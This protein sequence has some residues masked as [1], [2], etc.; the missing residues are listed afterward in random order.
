MMPR[1]HWFGLVIGMALTLAAAPSGAQAPTPA[2]PPPA[3]AIEGPV[4]IITFFEVDGAGSGKAARL[5]RPFAAATRQENGNAGFLALHESGRPGRFALVETW[6]DKAA[7]DAHSGAAA[8]LAEKL[9]PLLVAPFDTRLNG[10]LSVA[11]PAIGG[12][13]DAGGVAAYVLTHVDVFPAGK[14]QTIEMLKLLA[15]A[16]R[17]E[18]GNLRFEILQQAG[19]L[20]H[21]PIVEA[22]RSPAVRDAHL[23]AEHTKSFRAK[24]V[25]LQGALYDERVYRAVR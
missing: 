10:G 23:V 3:P 15:D 8:A 6:R 14:D 16:S 17:K 19:R 4:W 24:L 1:L 7:A 21:L 20:N 2:T 9:K 5:L 22:W 12:E 25:P 18:T 13:P 11:G